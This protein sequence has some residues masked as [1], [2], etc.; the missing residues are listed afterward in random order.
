MLPSLFDICSERVITEALEDSQD[1]VIVNGEIIFNI[2]YADDMVL[3]TSSK[4]MLQRMINKVNEAC[5][6]Y[7]MKLYAK[8]TKVMRVSKN[9]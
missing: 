9:K 1:G 7:G 8:N 3:A 6:K 5:K 2:R 4:E